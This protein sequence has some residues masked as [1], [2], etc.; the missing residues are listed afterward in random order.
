MN[1]DEI[2]IQMREKVSAS[3]FDRSVK[4]DCGA[5]GTVL[6]DGNT[7]STDDGPADCVIR[8]AKED[9]EAMVA[10][11]LDP[12]A[13]FMQGKLKIDGDMSVAMQLSQVI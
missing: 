5:D 3:D 12:T 2:A 11:K 8:L 10:G 7:V 9:L 1:M 6:I 13:A 4:F